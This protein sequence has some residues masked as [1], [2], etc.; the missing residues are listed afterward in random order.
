MTDGICYFVAKVQKKSMQNNSY[1]ELFS[2]LFAA[3]TIGRQARRRGGAAFAKSISGAM[4]VLC[5]CII[6]IYYYIL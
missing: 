6:I 5:I 1:P 2:D 4:E 3:L